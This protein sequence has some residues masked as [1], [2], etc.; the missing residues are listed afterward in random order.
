MVG[1]IP[2]VS[3]FGGESFEECCG[4]FRAGGSTP[5]GGAR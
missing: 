3:I 2:V 1:T 4:V 5:G